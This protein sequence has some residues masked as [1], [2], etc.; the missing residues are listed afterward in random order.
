[1]G[2]LT[3]LNQY[4]IGQLGDQIGTLWLGQ[5]FYYKKFDLL[6]FY[7]I[8]YFSQNPQNFD[9]I[10]F[11]N[12][13]NFI[14][15]ALSTFLGSFLSYN[16][17]TLLFLF[18]NSFSLFILLRNLRISKLISVTFST[19]FSVLPYFYFH[20]EHHTL[21]VLFPSILFINYLIKKDFVNFNRKDL[22]YIAILMNIQ[23][24]FSLYLGYFLGLYF[25]FYLV[26]VF[27][28]KKNKV[29]IYNF[30]TTIT[31]ASI[32]FLIFNFGAINSFINPTYSIKTYEFPNKLFE[33]QVSNYSFERERPLDDFLYFSSRPWYYFLYP[34]NHFL[35]GNSTK[36]II[37]YFSDKLDIWIFKNHFPAEHNSSF[38]GYTILILIILGFKYKIIQKNKLLITLF[39]LSLLLFILTLPPVLP[40][41]SLKIY[42]PSYL[43]YEIFPMFRS[44]SRIAI[45]I[46]I[47]FF[48][49]SA[50]ILNELLLKYRFK[51]K[52]LLSLIVSFLLVFEFLGNYKAMSLT[53][54]PE[55]NN[56][57]LEKNIRKYMVAAYPNNFRNEF[58]LNMVYHES[59]FFNPSGF[60]RKEINFNSSDFTSSI[61]TCDALNYFVAFNGKFIVIKNYEDSK[62]KI[63]N[64]LDTVFQSNSEKIQIKTTENL[65]DVCKN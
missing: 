49:I 54:L 7:S 36:E 44:T 12:I 22:L 39:T 6:R 23:T 10:F 27:F 52:I 19:I 16:I 5:I 40:I 30:V 37:N 60:V 63:I 57:L 43:M 8:E 56:F 41:G 13:Y 1:M 3:L 4:I 2:V 61:D 18:L 58:L 29:Y 42:T 33:N 31:F 14:Y 35:F 62:F 38:I 65:L 53:K 64:Q 45:Y 11:S 50:F 24:I 15:L 25:L 26:I 55:T 20:V 51:T 28:R 21:L 47:N 59:P 46:H 32:I 9:S 34:T 48:I 17:L